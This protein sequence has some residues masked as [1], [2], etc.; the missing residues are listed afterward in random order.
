[1]Y[2]PLLFDTGKLSECTET[3]EYIIAK[4]FTKFLF[5]KCYK[6]FVSQQDFLDFQGCNPL[7]SAL[8]RT[9]TDVL[10]IEKTSL[11]INDLYMTIKR[12]VG[13]SDKRYTFCKVYSKS[14]Y[15][16][17]VRRFIFNFYPDANDRKKSMLLVMFLHDWES[18]ADTFYKN[19]RIRFNGTSPKNDEYPQFDFK[20]VLLKPSDQSLI[21]D[22]D[23]LNLLPHSQL[24]SY[25][26]LLLPN[27]VRNLFH[28]S[29]PSEDFDQEIGTYG[30]LEMC[31]INPQKVFM[32]RKH[33][34]FK[35][36]EIPQND[37]FDS[38]VI[39]SMAMVLRQQETE[40]KVHRNTV[41]LATHH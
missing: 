35:I 39:L 29:N 28:S 25:S 33:G 24:L 9:T 15:G 34:I 31:N 4:Q 10:K 37:N 12:R 3:R 1:M 17:H 20:I 40:R 6:V 21:D 8:H 14:L 7:N 41:P 5:K 11:L 38:L 32:I 13:D 26:N 16:Y 2:D 36:K 18:Y 27:C 23:M 22:I 30:K 19:T